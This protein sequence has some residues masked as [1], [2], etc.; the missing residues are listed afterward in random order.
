MK[1]DTAIKMFFAAAT[2]ILYG[3]GG[4]GGGG[5]GGSTAPATVVSGVASKGPIVGGTVKIFALNA[6]GSKTLIATATTGSTGAYSAS[7]GSYTGPIYLEASGSYTDEATGQTLTISPAT[8]LRAALPA[9]SGTV[10]LSATPLTELAVQK[11]LALNPS[12]IGANIGASNAAISNMFK[13]DITA[14]AP[15]PPTRAAFSSPSVSQAQKDYALALAAISQLASQSGG[16]SAALSTLNGQLGTGSTLPPAAAASFSAALTSYLAPGNANNTTGVSNI[17]ATNLANL[18]GGSATVK[19]STV[20]SLPAGALIGAVQITLSLPAGV[21]LKADSLSGQTLAGVVAGSGGASGSLAV[22]KYIPANGATPA[23]VTLGVP[24][25]NGFALGEF[26]TL[27]CDLPAGAALPGADQFGV[28]TGK[29]VDP[30]SNTIS[31]ITFS[32]SVTAS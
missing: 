10:A 29:V 12:N 20:G 13:L 21:T 6:D 18:G 22:A 16:L 4:G 27:V 24:N 15:A 26:A 28:V 7:L 17:N 9:A 5:G 23:T 31:G 1:V 30:Q 11:A 25:A 3:C 8:P 32:F 14:T 19:I 2:L